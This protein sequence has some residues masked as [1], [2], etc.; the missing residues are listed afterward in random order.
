MS[1]KPVIFILH[2][3]WHGP[4]HFEP[5]KSRFEALGFTMLCPQQPSTGAVPPTRTLYDDAAHVRAEL[6]QLVEQ[7]KEVLLVMHSYGGMVGTQAAAGLGKA[8]R[9][10]GAQKGGI[11][12]LFYACAF[13]LPVGKS[14]VAG[15][16][17]LPPWEDGST[18]ATNPER[19]F[20]NDLPAEEQKLWVSKLKH[21]SII[22][23]KT[24]LTQVAYTSIPV[25]YLYCEEDQALPLPTQEMMVR[26]S[27]L[28][29]VQELRCGAGHSPFLSEPDLF[30]ES[31]IM[32]I[33]A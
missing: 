17:G 27:G 5:V 33:N 3:A 11:V 7:G 10:K 21:H 30:V 25:T 16:G 23:T 1:P 9:M 24:P 2:G 14:L 13:L 6:E 18:N 28:E 12:R 19:V 8:E 20:Y 29:D 32:S 15:L 31:I 4:A 22:A 26:Q